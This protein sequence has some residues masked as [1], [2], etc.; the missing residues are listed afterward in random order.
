MK[1]IFYFVLITLLVT[2]CNTD[3]KFSDPADY[4][5]EN[6]SYVL[7]ASDLESLKNNITNNNFLDELS[8]SK[9]F[10]SVSKKIDALKYFKTSNELLLCFSKDKNDSLQ[11]LI[12]TT[13][14]KDLFLV[15]SL[16]NHKIETITN[17]DYSITKTS[18]ENQVLFSVIKDSLFIGSSNMELLTKSLEKKN[19]PSELVEL[20][21]TANKNSQLSVLI[22]ENHNYFNSFF[23]NDSI[24]KLKIANY[25]LIDI[26]LKQDEILINGIT[27]ATDSSKSLIEV[28][29][30]TIPQE[31]QLAKITPSNSDGFL[32]F[33]FKNYSNFK[34]NLEAYQTVDSLTYDTTL[35]DNVVEVGVIFEG[36]QEAVVLNSLDDTS[37]NDALLN[38]QDIVETYRQI[39]ILNFS[40]PELF[41]QTFSPLVQ[42]N[43]ATH[44]C[45]LDNFFVFAN[46]TEM[47][48]NIIANYQ[49]NTTFEERPYFETIN[50][51][52]SNEA[53]LMLVVNPSKLNNKI[54]QFLDE[55]L[56]LNLDNYKASAI[57]FIY[58]SNFAHVNA[59]LK[60]SKTKA[61]ENS[62]T[63]EFNIKITEDILNTPQFVINHESD[64][65]EIVLQDV[66]NN[67]YLISNTGK[68][69]WKKQLDGPILGKVEQIDMYKNGRLQ[70]AF[71]T[72]NRVYVL[73]RAGKDVSP[74]P[75]KFNS[76]ITQPLSVFDYDNN[77][78][79]RLVVTQGKNILM[80]SQ[81]GKTIR[82]FNFKSAESDLIYQPQHIRIAKKDYLVF[83]TDSKLYILDRVGKTRVSP[84]NSYN[85]SNEAVYLYNDK[86][87]T[88]TKDGKLVSIDEK[89]NSTEQN[90]QLTERHHI[91][92]TSKTLV[93][94]SENKLTIKNKTLEMDYG[95]YTKPDIF[96]LN[97][98]IYVS[99]TDLQS[100]KI[101]LF[102]S[103]AKPIE[104]F[105]VYGN[106]RIILDNIDKDSNLEFVT[107][108]DNNSILIY[109]IN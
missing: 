53:S 102:D 31:N 16:P 23:L 1:G 7:K 34:Q 97:D 91:E 70:L 68:L 2:S 98:K 45:V 21:N 108:G 56:S 57:Q 72:P 17:K 52:L 60:K 44:Y 99:V 32:S 19:K 59:V 87:T 62:V 90:I 75:L 92:A 103:Q 48:Q 105:P 4:I 58:D 89:G 85:Y 84:K 51:N 18:V 109:Q 42:F 8:K 106:S 77:R 35:F 37:T 100:K 28:F 3:T 6:A 107:K 29:K 14:N 74:F 101:Y 15:D 79:Y 78:N 30:N 71:A 41:K 96:Y 26:D 63:E 24:S 66:K 25:L 40:K 46:S 55:N 27:K 82:G 93:A 88:T 20:L 86:F 36:E 67:L 10:S 73:D 43:K 94:Q 33:T 47:L 76:K 12:I 39:D 5:P 65:K 50:E 61:L 13:Y 9:T 104:N 38:E 54:E 49:N 69:L 11:Y 64:Q 95:N 81:L 83:K 80:Y 22:N